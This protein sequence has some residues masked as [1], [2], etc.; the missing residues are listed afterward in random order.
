MTKARD[1]NDFDRLGVAPDI[2][3]EPMGDQTGPEPGREPIVTERCQIILGPRADAN[4][5]AALRALERHPDLYLR[6]RLVRVLDDGQ[7]H[8]L[9][10]D[11]LLPML[12]AVADFA[13]VRVKDG[14]PV[15][16]RDGEFELVAVPPP[17][18]LAR[19][20][21]D[22]G[23]YPTLRV[24]DGVARSPIIHADGSVTDTPGYHPGSRLVYEPGGPTPSLIRHPTRQDAR[25]A[26]GRLLDVVAEFPLE[27]PADRSAWLAL[28]LTL[29]ARS[30]IR[31]C[32]PLFVASANQARVGKTRCIQLAELIV[33]GRTAPTIAWPRDPE[34]LRKRVDAVVFA[35][36]GLALFDNVRGP[37]VGEALEAVLTST[38]YAGRVL[39][40][41]EIRTIENVATVFAVSANG[42]TFAGDIAPR[43][44]PIRLHLDAPHPETR[45]FR[46]SDLVAWVRSRRLALLSDAITVVRA[47]LIAGRP[48]VGL[49]PWGSFEAWSALIRGALVWAGQPDPIETRAGIGEADRSEL[50]HQRLI[51]LVDALFQE[52]EWTAGQLADRVNAVDLVATHCIGLGWTA[53]DA[54][55]LFAELGLWD[56][57]TKEVDRH[58]LGKALPSHIERPAELPADPTHG[59]PK[60]VLR[61]V[62]VLD[63]TGQPRRTRAGAPMWC[64]RE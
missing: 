1:L 61:I 11:S 30:A 52:R 34:E 64:V 60:R 46:R 26:C 25:D 18:Q 47:Y 62:R 43:T 51:S 59:I 55:D 48:D 27:T 35:G 49:S 45:T 17:T 36:T 2:V 12:S 5:T 57:T 23:A 31:G 24:L 37:I 44:L 19:S 16:G 32:T 7:L 21:V 38:A 54:R 53:A 28:P 56:R 6:G 39:R 9:S 22:R 10:P 14:E 33:L 40:T 63:A 8:P 20:V 4:E 3:L 41:S 58:R 29:A 42:A 13:R 15:R 50:D